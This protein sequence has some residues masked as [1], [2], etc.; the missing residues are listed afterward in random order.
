MSGK[1]EKPVNTLREGAFLKSEQCES[2]W[3]GSAFGVCIEPGKRIGTRKEE[4]GQ[5]TMRG[6]STAFQ[7]AAYYFTPNT[8]DFHT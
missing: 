3:A 5:F 2:N 6:Y 1:G 4:T 7:F 8:P